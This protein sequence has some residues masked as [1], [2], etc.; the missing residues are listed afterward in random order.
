[1]TVHKMTHASASDI[2]WVEAA[3]RLHFGVLDLRGGL[4]RWFGGIGAASP[5]PTLL[6]S[7][8]RAG[9]LEVAGEDAERAREYARRVLSAFGVAGGARVTVARAIPPHV[10]LGSGT[11]LA[12]AVARALSELHGFTADTGELARALG[13]ARRSAIGTHAF[14]GGGLVVEGGHRPERGDVA[15]LLARIGFPPTWWCVVGV[16][17]TAPGI[18]GAA[19]RAAFA[20]LPP[21]PLRAVERVAHLVLM[22]LLPALADS[23]LEAFG[24][25]L[26]EI[27]SVTGEWFAPV[28]GGTYSPGAAAELVA[29]MK[30]RGARGV[31]QSSWGPA[32]YGLVEGPEAGE[33]LRRDVRAAIGSRGRVYAGPFPSNGARVW[34]GRDAARSGSGIVESREA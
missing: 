25:A 27:Q 12:L 11:Q 18:S 28:Q 4:G 34:R 24:E 7:A 23:D 19:E 13:R 3:A 30:A 8:V 32:V 2:V 1:V 5:G 29:R 10:G 14:D 20:R 22:G 6:V 33:R 21:P 9:Q 15:P 17:D 16:P 26:G 31:G